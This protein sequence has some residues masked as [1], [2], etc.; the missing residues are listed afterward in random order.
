MMNLKVIM[1]REKPSQ[2]YEEKTYRVKAAFCILLGIS[3]TQV[4]ASD[5]TK[6]MYT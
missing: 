2:G 6:Q 3:V 4:Y 5:K 1:L